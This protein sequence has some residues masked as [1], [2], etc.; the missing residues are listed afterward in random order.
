M[1]TSVYSTDG[2]GIVV[3]MSM[4]PRWHYSA[5]SR[6]MPKST[7]CGVI[8]FPEWTVAYAGLGWHEDWYVSPFD[9]PRGAL[10]LQTLTTCLEVRWFCMVVKPTRRHPIEHL[11]HSHQIQTSHADWPRACRTASKTGIDSPPPHCPIRPSS[12]TF[13][14]RGQGRWAIAV[15]SPSVSP[16]SLLVVLPATLQCRSGAMSGRSDL[17]ELVSSSFPFPSLASVLASS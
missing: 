3:V 2:L 7:C 16:I 12:H 17:L 4:L 10:T 9:S 11:R 15:A 13:G 6:S 5:S 1:P 14:N 8:Y